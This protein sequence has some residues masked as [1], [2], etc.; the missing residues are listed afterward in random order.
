MVGGI[1]LSFIVIL[2]GF[3]KRS[4]FAKIDFFVLTPAARCFGSA[5]RAAARSMIHSAGQELLV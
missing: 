4:I 5:A 1:L 2:R 3:T